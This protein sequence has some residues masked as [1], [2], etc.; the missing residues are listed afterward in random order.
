MFEELGRNLSHGK[1]TDLILLDFSKAFDVVNHL[2]LLVKLQMHG[3]HGK[4]LDWIRAFLLNRSQK[5]VV[6]GEESTEVPVTSGVP[7][8]SVL[9]PI[10]F[11]LYINDLPD[12]I[13][14]QVRLFADD[15]AVYLTINTKSDGT[16][17]QTDLDTMQAWEKKWDMSFNPSKCQ[18]MHI[19]KSRNPILMQYT[20]HDQILEAVDHAKY[21]GVELSSNLGWN[22]HIQSI[23]S[24]ASKSLG[25]IKRNLKVKNKVVRET[26]YKT[27]VRPQLE[28]ASTVWSPHT[29][30]NITRLEMV[31]RRAARWTL[32]RHS[33]LDS[34]TDMLHTL[35]WQ[36]LEQRRSTAKLCMMYKI[37]HQIVAIQIPPYF[38]HQTRPTRHSHPL[39][40]RQIHTHTN[41]Y[42]YSFFPLVVVQ[43]NRLPTEV[44][45]LTEL[46]QFKAA[47]Q[48]L[49][50][51]FP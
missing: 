29:Q 4:T 22:R 6:D 18:V 5:V 32:N 2:K 35:D 48:S 20:L 11:L 28:Y 14:S 31:Q 17:L 7:Q 24:K 39:A 9:G 27:L 45:M 34:V 46:S 44:A 38:Q 15:T 36:T 41:A 30:K 3:I 42:K 10:L 8:G 16:T 37:Y 26:A 50:Y 33:R 1:Q 47:V 40:L 19:T 13:K 23:T 51:T 25:F 49:V 21:L 43:W 12:N